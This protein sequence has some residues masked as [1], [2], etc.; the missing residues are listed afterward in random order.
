MDKKAVIIRKYFEL[1][2]LA[3]ADEHAL[4]EIIGLFS[5]KAVVKGANGFV[6]NTPV[7]IA[8]FFTH[9]FQD[10]QELHHLCHVVMD[11]GVYKAEWVVAGR[12]R[13]GQL[14]AYHGFDRYEF[15]QDDKIKFLQVE[16]G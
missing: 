14:F 4:S 9:F 12:K 11:Q 2:D 8:S 15:D 1:L 7:T 3:S 16:I 5:A 6:A 10:N 13:S